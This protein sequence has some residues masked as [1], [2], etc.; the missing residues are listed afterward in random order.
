MA[1]NSHHRAIFDLRRGGLHDWAR[2]HGWSGKDS[3][4]LPQHL[5]EEAAH[6]DNPHTAKM[7][8][9]ALNE[10]KFK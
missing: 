7:G 6:S 10:E 1:R 3:D 8:H 5:K 9:F 2:K 4:P